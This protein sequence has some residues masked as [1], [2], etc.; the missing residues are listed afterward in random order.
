MT[1]FLGAMNLETGEALTGLFMLGFM[2]VVFV[3]IPLLM[4][5]I[6]CKIY[7]REKRRKHGSGGEP[8]QPG[9]DM[10][11]ILPTAYLNGRFLPIEEAKVPALDR[12]FLFGDGVYEVVPYFR[13]QG[14]LL[15]AHL[16]RL[17]RS[18]EET[19]IR[20]PSH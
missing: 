15:D 10:S 1:P 14:L 7:F 5:W 17:E 6:G 9:I 13:N 11:A 4:W 20:N 2:F 19:G 8:P 3:M 12:G 16:D 18:L